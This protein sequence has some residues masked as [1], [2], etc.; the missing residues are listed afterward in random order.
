MRHALLASGSGGGDRSGCGGGGWDLDLLCGQVG[1]V[2]GGG[3][4]ARVARR[5]G[6]KLKGHHA[7]VFA[8]QRQYLRAGRGEGGIAAPAAALLRIF[9]FQDAQDGVYGHVDGRDSL[10]LVRCVQLRA[11]LA[12]GERGATARRCGGALA[13]TA[14]LSSGGLEDDA[15]IGQVEVA[16]GVGVELGGTEGGGQR[17]QHC[18]AVQKW[19]HGC[20]LPLRPVLVLDDLEITQQRRHLQQT[21]RRATLRAVARPPDGHRV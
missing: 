1:Q 13:A 10:P 18:L 17:V 14:I 21:G 15:V 16:R 20:G 3:G 2:V 4:L 5:G 7:E 8:V 9:L 19:R 12:G 11:V 6:R